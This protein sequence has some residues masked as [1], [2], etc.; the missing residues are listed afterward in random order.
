[1]TIS[2]DT[3]LTIASYALAIAGLQ[4]VGSLW[5]AFSATVYATAFT[6]YPRRS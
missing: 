5:G 3:L 6:L 4:L 1:M 2:Q